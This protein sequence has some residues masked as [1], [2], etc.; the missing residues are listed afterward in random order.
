MKP[1]TYACILLLTGAA[2]ALTAG[3][4]AACPMPTSGTGLATCQGPAN[5]TEPST[6]E[7]PVC[8]NTLCPGIEHNPTTGTCAQVWLQGDD[9]TKNVCVAVTLSS[10]DV[11]E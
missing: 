11:D 6:T 10:G 3:P 7:G 9:A 1:L 8:W 4:V 2:L 5:T